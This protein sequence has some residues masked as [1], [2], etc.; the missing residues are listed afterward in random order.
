MDPRVTYID[1]KEYP[2][3]SEDDDNFISVNTI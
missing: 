3:S 2:F 1:W